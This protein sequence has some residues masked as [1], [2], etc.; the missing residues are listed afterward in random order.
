MDTHGTEYTVCGHGERERERE[1]ERSHRK[2]EK[3]HE[4][5]KKTGNRTRKTKIGARR[6][7][8][9][10]VV[11]IV[12]CF[13]FSFTQLQVE[14]AALAAD[15]ADVGLVGLVGLVICAVPGR[16]RR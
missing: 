10:G 13:F 12:F 8:H 4:K 9:T 7:G 16:R 6:A 1:R 5:W 15:D 2:R 11:A 3:V 14:G